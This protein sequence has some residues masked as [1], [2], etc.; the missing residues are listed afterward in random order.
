[1]VPARTFTGPPLVYHFGVDWSAGGDVVE[2]PGSGTVDLWD[3][4]TLGLLGTLQVWAGD[5]VPDAL[6]LPDGH[7]LE[8][9]YGQEVGL[10]VDAADGA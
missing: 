1:M 4:H 3:A 9:S 6:G 2:T 7:T 8:L 5:Q 10:A